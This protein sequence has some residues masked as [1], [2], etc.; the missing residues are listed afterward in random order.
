M[1]QA[2]FHLLREYFILN[3]KKKIQREC[4]LVKVGQREQTNDSIMSH[5]D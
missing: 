2:N 5:V 4:L 3:A 1:F